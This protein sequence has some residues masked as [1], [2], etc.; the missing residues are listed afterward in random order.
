M[1]KQFEPSSEQRYSVAL[2]AGIGIP[3]DAIAGALG[4]SKPTL[5]KYFR[6][7]LDNGRVKTIAKVADSLVRQALAGNM[8]A[9]IFYLKTQAGWKE[10]GRLELAGYDGGPLDST[11]IDVKK[12]SSQ[13]LQELLSARDAAVRG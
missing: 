6:D 10:T 5:I 7:E 13:A 9:A 2:M 12:L 8:T 3:H 1:R 4:I 11:S